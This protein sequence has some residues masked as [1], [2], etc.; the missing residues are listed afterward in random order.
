MKALFMMEICFIGALKW[1][2]LKRTPKSYESIVYDGNLFHEKQGRFTFPL[3]LVLTAS[4]GRSPSRLFI[5]FRCLYVLFLF[6]Y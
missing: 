5:P 4:F 1:K 3:E 2:Q 6:C